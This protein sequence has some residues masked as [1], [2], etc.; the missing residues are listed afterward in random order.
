M[1]PDKRIDYALGDEI[2]RAR[3]DQH[4]TRAELVD[5]LPVDISAQALAHYEYGDRPCTTTRLVQICE[6]L[7]VSAPEL[8]NLAL[9]RAGIALYTNDVQVDLRV[10]ARGDATVLGPLRAWARNRL[11]AAPD[12]PG[13]AAVDQ[14]MINEWALML[15]MNK[16]DLV[17]VLLTFTPTAAPR[18]GR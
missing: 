1:T 13:T 12:G 6:A 11:A 4:L 8:L 10:M 16:Q 3:E 5:R 15:G 17:G 18:G 2:R 14:K 7:N 9:Q